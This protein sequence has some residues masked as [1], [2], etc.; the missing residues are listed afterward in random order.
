MPLRRRSAARIRPS[1]STSAARR[2]GDRAARWCRPRWR[3]RV[4]GVRTVPAVVTTA[5]G[6]DSTT[7]T[8]ST[9]RTPS[10]AGR[11]RRSR[12]RGRS[13]WRAAQCGVIRGGD[14]VGGPAACRQL[15]GLEQAQIVG[16]E[17]ERRAPRRPRRAAPYRCAGVRASVSVPPLAELHVDADGTGVDVGERRDLVDRVEQR[18]LQRDRRLATVS[19]RARRA[20]TDREQRRA[21]AAVAAARPE[22]DRGRAR[23]RTPAAVGSATH[24]ATARSTGRC[25]RRRRSRR[26]RRAGRTPR[27]TPPAWSRPSRLPPT[28]NGGQAGIGAIGAYATPGLCGTTGEHPTARR[29]RASPRRRGPPTTFA[30]PQAAQAGWYADPYRAGQLRYFDGHRWTHHSGHAGRRAAAPVE[31]TRCC[32]SSTALGATVVLAASLIV[33]RAVISV[34]RRSAGTS[35]C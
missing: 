16:A 22:A 29:R 32:R 7:S 30:P 17:A 21:P 14:H 34:D 23:R 9:M 10:R 26:R 12:G 20:E 4:I 15:V 35:S 27:R 8:P 33:N 24:A 28:A 2:A 31:S 19:G 5:R 13:G 18:P 1:S 11:R 3:A 6:R 25:S